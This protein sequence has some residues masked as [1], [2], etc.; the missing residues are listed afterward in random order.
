MFMLNPSLVKYF[1]LLLWAKHIKMSLLK[2]WI[3][4]RLKMFQ[5]R[6]FYLRLGIQP[7]STKQKVDAVMIGIFIWYNF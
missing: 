1:L 7:M 2:R 5:E 3:I 6:L 4:Y